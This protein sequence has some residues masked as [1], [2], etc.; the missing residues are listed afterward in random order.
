[1][2]FITNGYAQLDAPELECAVVNADG[3]I[4]INWSA[5]NDP[6]GNFTNYVIHELIETDVSVEIG[7]VANYNNTN[8]TATGVDGNDGTHCFFVFA[9]SNDGGGQLSASSDT[10]C[11]VFLQADNGL[12]PGTVELSWNYPVF[13][14]I[15][16]MTGDFAL[17]MEYPEG[18]WSP[19]LQTPLSSGIN[20]YTHQVDICEVDLDFQVRYSAGGTCNSFSNIDGG[21]Y[22][23]QIDPSPPEISSVSVDSLTN[24]AVISWAIP[25]EPDVSGYIIYECIPGLNPMPLDTI[26]DEQITSWVNP[27]SDANLSSE[28]YNIAAFDS[29]FTSPGNPDPG[30]ASLQCAN[31]IFLTHQW[32]PCTDEVTLIWSQYSGWTDGVA[33][34][35]IY[36]AEEPEPGSGNFEPSEVLGIVNGDENTFLHSDATLGSS[37]RYRVRAFANS[38][39]HTS[40]SN[41]RTAT[42]F[43]PNAPAYTEVRAVSV[44]GPDET[45][46]IVATDPNIGTIHEFILERKEANQQSY[47]II[48]AQEALGQ[49]ELLFFDSGLETSFTNYDYRVQVMNSCDDIVDTSN[50]GRTILLEGIVNNDRLVNTLF[51]NEYE[52]W[53][54]GVDYY[55]IFRRID[56]E[57]TPSL[58]TT[59]PGGV[60][61]YE[62][63][64]SDLLFT[65]GEFC[66][67]IVAHEGSNDQFIEEVSLSNE[68]CLTQSPVIWVPNAFVVNGVNRTFQPVISFADFNNYRMVIYSRWGDVIFETTNIE[69]GWDGTFNNELV[70]EGM[71]AF[72]ISVADGAGRIYEERGTL[73]M[74]ISGL[75]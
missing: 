1:M 19:I 13:G 61:F 68:L 63:D 69:K 10:L 47:Q 25:P 8:F 42:L 75:D 38:G 21:T 46:I 36:A 34:Y 72:Y 37:Y 74:L 51:W 11:S 56:N 15:A 62:D 27:E 23:D 2:L 67:F 59:V 35:E 31:T 18:T 45:S 26:Y 66:Y 41:N 58:V 30:A 33:F 54:A 28:G 3:S 32:Q 50:F 12:Q 57:V 39:G 49:N 6:N 55:S 16:E 7:T 44:D 24:D 4:S 22:Q 64:V 70:P 53:S 29:C 20:T 73:T 40:S 14:I 60:T 9:G 48:D 52:E 43:Y 71:Y 5:P 17:L 65:E